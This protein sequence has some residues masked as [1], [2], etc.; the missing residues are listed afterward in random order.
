MTFEFPGLGKHH[1]V[2]L[3]LGFSPFSHNSTSS[4][5]DEHNIGGFPHSAFDIGVKIPL[6]HL[7]K[8]N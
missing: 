1:D 5:D 8:K 7:F 6:S 2:E 3:D 4:H